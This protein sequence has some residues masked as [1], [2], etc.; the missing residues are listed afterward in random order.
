MGKQNQAIEPLQRWLLRVMEVQPCRAVLFP[1]SHAAAVRARATGAAAVDYLFPCPLRLTPQLGVDLHG[2]P[3]LRCG[4][5][6]G[7]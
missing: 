1:T 3:M 4:W 5:P 7:S 2:E 6:A